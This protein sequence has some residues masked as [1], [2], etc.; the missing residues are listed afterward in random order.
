MTK[1]TGW[2][3]MGERLI[4]FVPHGN[5]KTQTLIAGLRCH[6][7]V[8]PW[9]IDRAM[10][11]ELFELYVETQL[12]PELNRGDVVLLD[13]LSSHKSEKAKQMLKE[14]GAWFLFLPKYSPDLNPIEMAFS[15][16]KAHL[17]KAGARTFDDVWKFEFI[18][19]LKSL[20]CLLRPGRNAFVTAASCEAHLVYGRQS[21]CCRPPIPLPAGVTFR[22]WDPTG[23]RLF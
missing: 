1:Q 13:N 5:W 8:A 2:A 7:L 19:F 9:V 18:A 12:V 11:K 20:F 3:P 16:L 23:G 17:R 14:V 10:N 21:F 15:K 4:D 22:R 6:G